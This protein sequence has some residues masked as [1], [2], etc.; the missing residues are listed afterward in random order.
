MSEIREYEVFEVENFRFSP[1]NLLPS[2]IS[3]G[4]KFLKIEKYEFSASFCTLNQ[5]H[6]PKTRKSRFGQNLRI[7][8]EI[9]QKIRSQTFK[10][11]PDFRQNP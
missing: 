4:P 3:T 7:L 10:I 5:V 6:D 8:A 9:Q 2:E 11:D 1:Q